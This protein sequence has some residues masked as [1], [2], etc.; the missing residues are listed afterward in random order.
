M[1]CKANQIP[2]RWGAALDAQSLWPD[3]KAVSTVDRN[4]NRAPI[5]IGGCPR[6]FL[7]VR[8]CSKFP[9]DRDCGGF[10]DRAR[11]ASPL[12]ATLGHPIHPAVGSSL[13]HCRH[14]GLAGLHQRGKNEVGVRIDRAYAACLLIW[15]APQEL[16][17]EA[18]VVASRC[19]PGT[20]S[21]REFR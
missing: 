2:R 14:P 17:T 5:G 8:W 21:S 19:C 12:R 11:Q 20:L 9:F 15:A 18:E 7:A 6:H 1:V 3:A 4:G 13:E 10:I 16:I